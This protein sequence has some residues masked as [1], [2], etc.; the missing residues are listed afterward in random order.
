[1]SGYPF[2]VVPHPFG[3]IDLAEAQARADAITPEVEQLLLEKPAAAT[4]A[5]VV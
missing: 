1:M 4:E 2:A 3:S 5:R